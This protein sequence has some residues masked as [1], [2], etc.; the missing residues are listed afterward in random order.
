MY[1][2]P[3]AD[4]PHRDASDGPGIGVEVH[5]HA[6]VG[7]DELVQVGGGIPEDLPPILIG[8]EVGHVRVRKGGGEVCPVPGFWD[9][10]PGGVDSLLS[11][12]W[13]VHELPIVPFPD[14]GLVVRLPL[15]GGCSTAGGVVSISLEGALGGRG[16][17]REIGLVRGHLEVDGPWRG[18]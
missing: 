11:S 12:L 6:V 15:V 1:L 9:R 18:R 14:P 5:Q 7:L 13:D 4:I 10:R 3:L 17:L 8:G 2:F 16:G